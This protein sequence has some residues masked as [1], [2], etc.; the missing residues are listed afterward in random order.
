MGPETFRALMGSHPGA[1]AVITTADEQG[2]PYGFTCTALCSLSL[3]PPLLLVCASN[4]GSTLPVLV[5]R[6]EFAVNFLHSQ[7]RR[8]AEAFASRTAGRFAAVP[9]QTAP[10]SDLPLLP[11]DSHALAR[12]RLDRLHPAG[13]HTI[14]I[15]EVVWT[16]TPPHPSTGAPTDASPTAGPGPL[17]Y[18]RRQYAAWP[19]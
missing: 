4:T 14:V 11:Q 18:G 9:W 2:N 17:L 13:D 1:V 5:E 8:A 7:G 6:G 12:C 3:D 10:G 15:G 16:H 19:D